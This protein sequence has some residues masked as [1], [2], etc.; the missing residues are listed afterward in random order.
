MRNKILLVILVFFFNEIS[1]AENIKISAKNVILDKNK[2]STIFE[3]EVLVLTNEGDNIKSDYAEYNKNLG[4][5]T[6]K[7]NV[8]LIDKDNNVLTANF[9]E[10][11]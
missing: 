5:L 10:Y 1:F 3:N 7:G 11:K 2:Q 8:N 4:I 6:L 9:I